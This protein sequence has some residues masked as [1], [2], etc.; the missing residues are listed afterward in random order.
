MANSAGWVN[1]VSS[2]PSA[3]PKITSRSPA[4]KCF[5]T[6]SSASANTANRPYS[7]RPI[8]ARCAPW[9][10]N[11]TASERPVS[12]RPRAAS[13]SSPSGHRAS[14]TARCSKTERPLASEKPTS[15]G[16]DAPRS[17]KIRSICAARASSDLADT[18]QGTTA[19]ATS[20]SGAGSSAGAACSTITWALVPLMPNDETP[21]RHG[22]SAAGHSR[23]PVARSSTAPDAQSTCDDGVSTCKVCGST[24]CRIA[25]T[26]LMI[27]ATP[28][29]AWVWPRLDFTEP[30]SNGRSGSRSWP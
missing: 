7:S 10:E 25:R 23:G 18:G 16:D 9:P 11:S 14:S 29:A 12:A 30:S 21:A 5:S 19:G 1:P 13:D 8:P 2:R 17:D 27:P 15:A 20:D 3:S 26:I 22:R 28:A 6:A 4:S 24:P